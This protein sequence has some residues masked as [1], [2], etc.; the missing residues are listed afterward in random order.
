VTEQRFTAVLADSGR[1]G[2]RWLELPFDP[3]EVFGE[4]RPP[5]TGTLNGTPFRGRLSVYGGKTY[6]GLNKEIRNA[7]AIDVGDRVEVVLDRDEAPREV[8]IP[9][10]LLVAFERDSAAKAIFDKLAFTHRKEYARWIAE[11]KK[12]ETR[13]R[14]T[15]KALEMLKEGQTLS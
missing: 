9:Q 13:E 8:E 6:L 15:A 7:A 14:R 3:N 12:E 10:E 11:A 5:V 4:A 1:G 2:G